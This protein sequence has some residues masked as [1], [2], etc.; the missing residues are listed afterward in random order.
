MSRPPGP[1]A[2]AILLGS[3]VVLTLALVAGS[4]WGAQAFVGACLVGS[5]VAGQVVTGLK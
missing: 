5:I 1:S 2:A 4:A 3:L